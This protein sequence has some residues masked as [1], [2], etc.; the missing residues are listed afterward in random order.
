MSLFGIPDPTVWLAYVG[1]VLCVVFCAV[2]AYLKDKE[3]PEDD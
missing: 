3:A 2:W 1:S